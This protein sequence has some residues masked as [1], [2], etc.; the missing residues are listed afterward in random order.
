[1]TLTS[2]SNSLPDTLRPIAG[3]MSTVSSA[4][5]AQLAY[6]SVV[7]TSH[8][9]RSESSRI[10]LVASPRKSDGRLGASDVLGAYWNA[11]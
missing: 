4:L 8:Q 6:M 3:S 1:M 2:S 7:T 5:L 10:P 9:E 11:R